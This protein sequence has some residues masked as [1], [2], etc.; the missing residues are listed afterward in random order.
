MMEVR[1]KRTILMSKE[2]ELQELIEYMA[3]LHQAELQRRKRDEAV[4]ELLNH[5]LEQVL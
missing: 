3:D 2:A 5:V 4:N 1:V